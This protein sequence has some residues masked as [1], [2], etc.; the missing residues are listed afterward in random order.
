VARLGKGSGDIQINLELAGTLD[1]FT[2]LKAQDSD[3]VYFADPGQKSIFSQGKAMP[4]GWTFDGSLSYPV[5]GMF[6]VR[7][8]GGYRAQQWKFTYTDFTQFRAFNA[9]G[10]VVVPPIFIPGAAIEFSEYYDMWYGGGILTIDFNLGGLSPRLASLQLLFKGQGDYAY[11]LGKN[12]DFHILRKPAPRYTQERTSGGAW[13]VNLTV[14]CRVNNRLALTVEG[15]LIGIQTG[16][17]HNL[18]EPG[19]DLTWEGSKV[20]SEQ[21]YV[22]A[23]G[24][25]TF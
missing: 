18:T 17:N 3:W 13:H 6:F 21:K 10:P 15:D 4:R 19:I 25:L 8:V 23:T 7:G 12:F 2:N 22:T 11:V 14:G 5:P 24:I 16:G 20:W 1:V 9:F